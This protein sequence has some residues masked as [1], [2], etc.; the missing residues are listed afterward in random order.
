MARE[1]TSYNTVDCFHPAKQTRR[2]RMV[3]KISVL[4]LPALLLQA[5]SARAQEPLN[6]EAPL[7]QTGEAGGAPSQG[8]LTLAAAQR[9]QELGLPLVA[10]GLYRQLLAV[11]AGAAGDRA[12]M[13]LA[14]V[15]ALLDGGDIPGA[16]Q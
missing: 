11:P 15:T 3:S 12:Q 6:R 1:G 4:L 13:T 9:A 16:A 10:A 7:L 2:S 5:L 14:L 8:A